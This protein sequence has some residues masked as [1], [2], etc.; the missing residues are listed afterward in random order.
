MP[1]AS[2]P[3][4]APPLPP[5][6]RL[7]EHRAVFRRGPGARQIGLDPDTAL[8]VDGLPPA[9]SQMLDELGTAVPS[10]ALVAAAARRGAEPGAAEA[11]LRELVAAGAVVDAAAARRRDRHRADSVVVVSGAGPLAV[12]IAVGLTRAGVG[13]VHVETSATVLAEDLGTGYLD[14]DRGR[15]RLAATVAAVRRLRPGARS[16][17]PPARSVP[18]LVVLADASAPDPRRTAGLHVTGTAHLPVRLRDGVG[19]VGPLVLPGRST[20]LTCLELHRR[21]HDPGW[22]DVAA[23]LAG[24]RGRADPACVVATGGLGTAQALAALDTTAA[25]HRPPPVLDATLELDPSAGTLLRRAWAAHP[26]C[27]CGAAT[28]PGG[29]AGPR[30]GDMRDAPGARDTEGVNGARVH[31]RTPLRS[32]IHDRTGAPGAGEELT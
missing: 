19:V 28:G 6:L 31:D 13:T 27:G 20:C 7:A 25:G 16:G 26:E 17:P 29:W 2:A 21:G 12:G 22:P 23:Q 4:P 14:A 24:C 15:D 18:D 5:S 9:L 10:A 1:T 11:L 8:A 3:L 30:K 32:D